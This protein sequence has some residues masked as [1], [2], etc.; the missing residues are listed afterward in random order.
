MK[1][2][3]FPVA[4]A[5]LL[6]LTAALSGCPLYGDES[7]CQDDSDCFSGETCDSQAG[8]CRLAEARC[9][10]PS[11]CGT[12]ETCGRSGICLPGDCSFERVGCVEGY[13]CSSS[14]GIWH[15]QDGGAGQAGA[16]GGAGRGGADGGAG[17]GA[18]QG[19]AT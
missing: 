4:G 14:S 8:L 11:D 6:L 2:S 10:E 18:A 1:K 19:G 13:E 17:A 7:G 3:A 5:A 16:D 9:D 12:N 15:C